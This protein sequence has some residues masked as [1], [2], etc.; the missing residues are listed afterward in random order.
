MSESVEIRELCAGDTER[1]VE[2]ALAA[3]APIYASFR[4]MLGEELFTRM[5]PDW[6]ASKGDQIRSACEDS[7]GGVLVAHVDHAIVGF[8]TY[9]PGVPKAGMATIGNNAVDPACQGRGI[10]S[11]MYEEVFRRLREQGIDAVKVGTGGDASHAPARA[12]YEKVGFDIAVP[13]VDYWRR[14]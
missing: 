11:Q 3:W 6:H 10:G 4:E 1:L 8:V 14:L 2:I 7:R 5:H 12:A 13:H 9:F